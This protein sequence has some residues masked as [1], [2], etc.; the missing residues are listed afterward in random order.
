MVSPRAISLRGVTALR[1][2]ARRVLGVY[3]DRLDTEVA[4][5][6]GHELVE[7]S[8]RPQVKPVRLGKRFANVGQVLEG[9]GPA[10]VLPGLGDDSFGDAVEI[11]SDVSTLALADPLQCSTCTPGPYLLESPTALFEL[12]TPMVE[13]STG[14]ERGRTR[15][16]EIID[17]EVNPENRSVLGGVVGAFRRSAKAQMEEEVAVPNC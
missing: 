14:E 11:I 6:V 9:D 16:R 7:S 5:F 10:V 4:R 2:S 8:K 12:A 17:A 15:D 1:T 13:F 3:L